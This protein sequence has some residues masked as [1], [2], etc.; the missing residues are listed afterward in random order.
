MANQY[1]WEKDGKTYRISLDNTEKATL[2]RKNI[3]SA[4]GDGKAGKNSYL[5]KPE[6]RFDKSL[7]IYDGNNEKKLGALQFRWLDFQKSSLTLES[8]KTFYWRSHELLKGVWAWYEQDKPNPTMTFRVDNPLHRSGNIELVNTKMAAAD[9][10][11]LL[12]F[13][14][15]LQ[16]FINTW[17]IIAVLVLIAVLT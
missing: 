11:L 16:T 5:F 13:G 8:G 15:L 2:D 14:V 3:F 4:E 12:S 9:R 6:G 7:T 1:Q 10:D 17:M